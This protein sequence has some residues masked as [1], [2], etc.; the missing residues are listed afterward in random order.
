MQ[1]FLLVGLGDSNGSGQAN[2]PFW[3]RQCDRSTHS[4]QMRVAQY[5]ERLTPA[6]PSLSCT[7]PAR[8]R[9]RCMWRTGR[10]WGEEP[11]A[12]SGL[13]PRP[14][15]GVLRRVLAAGKPVREIDAM[16]LSIGIN[17]LRFGGIL[18]VCVG[19]AGESPDNRGA[20]PAIT[21]R[22]D[23]LPTR[24]ASRRSS[25]PPPVVPDRR[26]AAHPLS[27]RSCAICP[28]VTRSWPRSHREACNREPEADPRD[29]L[30]RCV[31]A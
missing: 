11:G 17:D 19:N 30:S 8:E 13:M 2:P 6:R 22:S 29:D 31:V 1:D 20:S 27:T 12:G 9:G 7:S 5:V 15:L 24:T 21:C 23:A 26:H 16:I 4:Y 10:T 14:Q 3:N 25:R 28:G 18:G